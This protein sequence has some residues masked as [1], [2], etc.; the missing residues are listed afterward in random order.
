MIAAVLAVAVAISAAADFKREGVVFSNPD[1]N[2]HEI[3]KTADGRYRAYFMDHGKI[4]SAISSDGRRF[5]LEDGVRVEGDHPGI[6]RLK[7]GR[8]RIYFS[9]FGQPGLRSA[10]SADGLTFQVEDGI[11]LA[12]GR[13]GAPDERGMIHPS[14]VRLPDGRTRIYYDAVGEPDSQFD[15]GWNGVMSATSKDG[16]SFKR[17][18]GLRLDSDDIPASGMVWSPFV[19]REGRRWAMYVTSEAH[20]DP[21]RMGGVWRATSGNGLGFSSDAKRPFFGVDPKATNVQ[22]GP[23]GPRNTPQDVFILKVRG[24]ERIFY[25]E[26]GEGTLS[27]F[28]SR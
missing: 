7:N 10:V 17:D 6:I 3:V 18:K 12:G 11:R 4:F 5:E 27:A 20:R 15:L 23:G 2:N 22:G 21:K 9:R 13:R 24:G 14:V 26:A 1:W 19:R 28:R 8:I 25:W 16:L